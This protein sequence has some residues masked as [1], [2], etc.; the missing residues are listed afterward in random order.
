M[1][2]SEIKE[3]NPKHEIKNDKRNVLAQTGHGTQRSVA[4]GKAYSSRR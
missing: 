2:V 3:R 4:D 1:P